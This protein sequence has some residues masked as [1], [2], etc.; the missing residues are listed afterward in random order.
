MTDDEL[1][2]FY[3]K[4]QQ[5]L[6]RS[7]NFKSGAINYGVCGL[8]NLGNTCFMNAVLQCLSN[9]EKLTRYL[10][11]DEW[12]ENINPI[13]TKSGGRLIIEYHQL[14]NEMW[15]KEQEFCSPD[16]IKKTIGRVNKQFTGYSQHDAQ[17]FLSYFLDTLCEEVN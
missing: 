12:V 14:L 15:C 4:K 2:Q 10:L 1:K 11:Q 9:T 13:M 5:E 8:K 6:I 16:Q 3:I 17:E 7:S